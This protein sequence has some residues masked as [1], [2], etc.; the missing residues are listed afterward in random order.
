MLGRSPKGTDGPEG[1]GIFYLDLESRG[2]LVEKL[3]ERLLEAA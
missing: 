3:G 2:F 1:S